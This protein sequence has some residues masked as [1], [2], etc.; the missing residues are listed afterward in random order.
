MKVSFDAGLR[1][2]RALGPARDADQP[3][4][5]LCR[6]RQVEHELARSVV[7]LQVIAKSCVM[8]VVTFVDDPL[9]GRHSLS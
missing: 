7:H 2:R 9:D 1:K 4:P 6:S 5:G 3:G 8:A